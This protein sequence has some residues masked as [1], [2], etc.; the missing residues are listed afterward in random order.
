[1]TPE[2]EGRFLTTG[3]PGVHTCSMCPTLCNPVDCSQAPLPM[4]FSRQKYWSML[5]RPPPGDLPNPG[6]EPTSVVSPALSG[7]F[8]TTGATW[9]HLETPG[10]P[11]MSFIYPLRKE[12]RIPPKL[13]YLSMASHC[14][15]S[16]IQY[17]QPGLSDPA[18][19]GS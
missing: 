4:R 18:G 3:P 8:V 10:P 6:I 16:K 15:Q 11:G 7:R 12:I 1:M 13:I 5:P 14:S 2:L 17:S 19:S 9:T